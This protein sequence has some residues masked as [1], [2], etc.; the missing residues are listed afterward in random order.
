MH[1]QGRGRCWV[2]SRRPGLNGRVLLTVSFTMGNLNTSM[3]WQNLGRWS[4]SGAH[5]APPSFTASNPTA[6]PSRHRFGFLGSTKALLDQR[7][8]G[9][10]T[11]CF[12]GRAYPQLALIVRVSRAVAGRG[13]LPLVAA[14]A[15]TVAVSS[16]TGPA[17]VRLT[18]MGSQGLSRLGRRPPSARLIVRDSVGPC[19][20]VVA[21]FLLLAGGWRRECVRRVRMPW[22]GLHLVGLS[23]QC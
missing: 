5:R 9:P 20:R 10:P 11:F 19:C 2:R 16:A 6:R 4:D 12:S 14:V 23:G 7:P 8:G 1:C 3:T 13:C 18:R 17:A 21:W 15:V 22:L